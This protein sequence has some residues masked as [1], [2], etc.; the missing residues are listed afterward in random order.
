MSQKQ[1]TTKGVATTEGP[2]TVRTIAAPLCALLLAGCSIQSTTNPKAFE[3]AAIGVIGNRALDQPAHIVG[4]RYIM[5]GRWYQPRHQPDY[6]ATGPANRYNDER[7]GKPT[8]NGETADA[9][10]IFA[11]HPTLPLPSYVEVTHLATGKVLTVRVNDR[12]PFNGRA[13]ITLSERAAEILGL[14]HGTQSWV[15]VRYMSPAPI[16]HI[17]RVSGTSSPKR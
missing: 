14:G 5:N 7:T 11:A 16:E 6:D 17:G 8:A 2:A 10:N 13:I 1:K 12:G 9:R 4:S 3:S 15:R